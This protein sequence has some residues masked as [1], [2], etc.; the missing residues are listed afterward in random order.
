MYIY[1][2]LSVMDTQKMIKSKT[3]DARKA[4]NKVYFKNY[5]AKNSA[6]ILA[7]QKARR[8]IIKMEM[9]RAQSGH[10]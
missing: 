4:Y 1:L 8:E 2:R 7:Q 9:Q 3:S 10:N 6:K 5:Y